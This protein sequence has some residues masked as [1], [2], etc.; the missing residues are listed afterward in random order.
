M[1]HEMGNRHDWFSIAM[2]YSRVYSRAYRVAII[3]TTT[4]SLMFANALFYSISYPDSIC[5][6]YQ[7]NLTGCLNQKSR[8]NK[9]PVCQWDPTTSECSYVPPDTSF[10]FQI[11]LA[12]VSSIFTLPINMVIKLIFERMVLPKTKGND[13]KYK[14][15]QAE[16][17][18]PITRQDTYEGFGDP[19]F[20]APAEGITMV[21]Q[22][23]QKK[24]KWS[25]IR[26]NQETAINQAKVLDP[27]LGESEMTKKATL[28]SPKFAILVNNRLK[29]A[30]FNQ[31]VDSETAKLIARAQEHRA[32]LTEVVD[33][34]EGHLHGAA[35]IS[36]TALTSEQKQHLV[37]WIERL[38][39]FQEEFDRRWSFDPKGQICQPTLWENIRGKSPYKRIRKM[40][41]RDLIMAGKLETVLRSLPADERE[42]RLMVSGPS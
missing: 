25:K 38:K 1:V 10:A 22:Q 40:V 24:S 13:D 39:D 31:L 29:K 16:A 26:N 23:S 18:P 17:L 32:E 9:Q 28:S 27:S 35:G 36:P 37:E 5:T 4:F 3:T 33:L 12:I 34:L 8:I 15:E 6:P 2:V 42:I 11:A 21:R 41:K 30:K 19:T 14:E 7:H 20:E